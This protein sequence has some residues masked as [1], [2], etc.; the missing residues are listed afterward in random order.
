MQRRRALAPFV[1]ATK[2][3]AVDRDN[4][5]FEIDLV[6]A[7]KGSN[8]TMERLLECDRI[9]HPKD[10]AERVVAGNAMFQPQDA[11]K[12]PLLGVPESLHV[13]RSLGTAKKRSQGD[14]Q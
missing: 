7:R 5:L 14:K 13:G 4:A 3:L 2:R 12:K 9:E 11:A 1:G 6:G 10:P 8:K